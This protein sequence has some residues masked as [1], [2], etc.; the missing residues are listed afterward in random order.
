MKTFS[1]RSADRAP[2]R[3]LTLAA[4]VAAV[5]AAWAPAS[6]LAVTTHRV[7]SCADVVVPVGCATGDDGTLRQAL[8]CAQSNDIVDLTTLQCSRIT[9]AQA[10]IVGTITVTVNGPGQDR[11]AIDAH[12]HSR[13]LIHN[14]TG[15]NTLNLNNLSIVNG[16]YANPYSY[17]GGGGCIFS[18][19]SVTLISST[20]S[21]CV[22]NATLTP[23]TGGAIYARSSAYLKDSVVAESDVLNF[24][25]HAS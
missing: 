19:G 25:G 20:V 13:A 21:N 16:Y 10:L 23:A 14:G 5:A 17:G 9:L 3:L 7:T 4:H 24:G 15:G 18:D 2:P 22:A 11:L 1:F 8:Q 6:S 12:Q